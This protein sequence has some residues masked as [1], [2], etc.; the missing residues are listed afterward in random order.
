[1]KNRRSGFT[2][3]ELMIVIAIVGILASVA[4]PSY[5]HHVRTAQCA[6]GIDSLLSLAGRM[7]DF[8]LNNDSYVGAAV[9]SATSSEGLF[10]L[11][12]GSQTAFSYMLQ[13]TPSAGNAELSTLT[14]NS[15]GQW[16]DVDAA[17]EVGNCL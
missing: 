13:A 12:I 10:D 3:V 6:D 2:L 14:L 16:T 1:M 8:Y 9:A 15:L 5:L 7:E 11:A 17:G 4:F